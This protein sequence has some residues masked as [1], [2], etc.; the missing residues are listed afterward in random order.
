MTR[1]PARLL[2]DTLRFHAGAAPEAL[3]AEWATVENE[4]LDHL[5]VFESCG[6]WLY[7]RLRQIGAVPGLDP[8]FRDWLAELTREETARNLIVDAEARAIAVMLA[9]LGVPGVFLKGIAR[10][11]GVERYPLA[12]AL[13][14]NDVDVL[15][16][17]ARARAV[18]YELRR[19][20]YQRTKPRKPRRPEHHHLPAL[21]SDRLVGVEVHTTTDQRVAPAE[22]WSR[23]HGRGEDVV[24]DGVTYRVPSATDL[25]WSGAAHGLLIPDIAFVMVRFLASA[26]IWA[27]GRPIDWPEIRRRLET[28][29]LVDRAAAGAWL[30]AVAQVVGVEPPAE[31]TDLL[32]PFDLHR[33]LELRLAVLRRLPLPRS[34][35]KGLAWWSSDRARR[36]R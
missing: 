31:L 30:N 27:A 18:W 26:V 20:G 36:V 13:L 28:K 22:A 7:R 33:A 2:L 25:F 11:V 5:V 15:L 35:W 23:V 14:T 12:D 16:P 4:G 9:E 19:R 3:A 8:D 6:S 10:R 17:A 32:E 34:L 29:E 21:M 1:Q 24:R